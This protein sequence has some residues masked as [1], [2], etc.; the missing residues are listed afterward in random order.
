M[1]AEAYARVGR[2]GFRIAADASLAPAQRSEYLREARSAEEQNLNINTDM[3]NR[4][5]INPTPIGVLD[6]TLNDIASELAK[7]DAV[8]KTVS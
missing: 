4:G 7:I 3:H 6:H 2:I 5:L 8:L 1:L